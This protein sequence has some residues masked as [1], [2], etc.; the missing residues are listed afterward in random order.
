[1]KDVKVSI[2]DFWVNPKG[3]DIA[4]YWQ[5]LKNVPFDSNTKEQ[6]VDYS[7]GRVKEEVKK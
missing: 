1:M 3:T 2:R 7:E 6:M 4:N 5:N